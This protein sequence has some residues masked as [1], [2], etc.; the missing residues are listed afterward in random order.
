MKKEELYIKIKDICEI[1]T[2]NNASWDKN[3]F[4][5]GFMIVTQYKK[6]GGEQQE[7]YNTLHVLYQKYAEQT[8]DETKMDYI[9]DLLDCIC[10][11]VGFVRHRLINYKILKMKTMMKVYPL[12]SYYLLSHFLISS[13]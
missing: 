7:A 6:E 5:K 12:K 9:A 1:L 8:V 11:W 4:Q 13:N 3:L 2:V 10:G